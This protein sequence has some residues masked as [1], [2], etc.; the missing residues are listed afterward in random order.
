MSKFLGI[1]LTVV[2]VAA[3]VG[4]AIGWRFPFIGQSRS[5]N[6]VETVQDAPTAGQP[7]TRTRV[8]PAN[9][10]TRVQPANQPTTTAQAQNNQRTVQAPAQ[11]TVPTIDPEGTAGTG[12]GQTNPSEPIR[13]LW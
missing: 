2:G 7:A 8:Q 3:L 9:Q 11:T 4:A 6:Q 13:A 5:S 1:I 10:P 12:T